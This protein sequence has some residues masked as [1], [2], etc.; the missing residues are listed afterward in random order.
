MRGGGFFT[1]M[2]VA[3]LEAA[4]TADTLILPPPTLTEPGAPSTVAGL[5]A[6]AAVGPHRRLRAQL[7]T[8][9]PAWL[10]G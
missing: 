4:D 3:G 1:L 6:P 5:A 7:G 2:A 9:P 10:T 8:T